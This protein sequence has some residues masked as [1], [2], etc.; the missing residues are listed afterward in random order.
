M[1]T[2]F[3][4]LLNLK[5]VPVLVTSIIRTVSDQ[6]LEKCLLWST[7]WLIMLS[8]TSNENDPNFQND[9]E[10]LI[11]MKHTETTFIKNCLCSNIFARWNTLKGLH[12]FLN[13]NSIV[14]LLVGYCIPDSCTETSVIIQNRDWKQGQISTYFMWSLLLFLSNIFQNFLH[15]WLDW[16]E[17]YFHI[18]LRVIYFSF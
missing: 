17:K 12:I 5:G 10:Y 15:G 6:I 8:N 18:T 4:C 14:F 3:L 7:L 11:Q 16:N 13:Y 2:T 9:W 1:F